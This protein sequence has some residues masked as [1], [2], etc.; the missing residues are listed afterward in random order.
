MTL[1]ANYRLFINTFVEN[2]G[3]KKKSNK[4]LENFISVDEYKEIS[5]SF[6]SYDWEKDS[7]EFCFERLEAF[8]QGYFKNKPKV[9]SSKFLT[10]R[11]VYRGEFD[12]IESIPSVFELK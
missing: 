1:P 2:L 12:Q 11:V 6:F 7:D 8:I 10:D 4:A 9:D 5:K 3:N